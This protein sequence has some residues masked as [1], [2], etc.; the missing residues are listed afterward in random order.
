MPALTELSTHQLIEHV[1]SQHHAMAGAVIALSA[2]Q[3]C[4]LG[5]ACVRISGQQLQ[6][7]A[8]QAMA[9]RAIGELDV[10]KRRLLA[11]ADQDADAIAVFVAL[12]A[13]C[14]R[15]AAAGGE[16]LA[17]QEM[18]C[19]APVHTGRL[20]F[21]AALTLQDF[22]SCVVEQVRDDLEMA[23]VLLAGAARAAALLLDSN[24]RIWPEA[25]LQTRYEPLRV[26]LETA[27][28]RLTPVNRIRT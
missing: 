15:V 6:D 16:M 25:A 22:R 7:R 5:E 20:A 17:G 21:A 23:I 9:A 3:A 24:L 4:A 2:A 26:D 10:S 19:E 28:A 11:L 13:A 1:G 8:R 12:R 14:P 27:I 18:L